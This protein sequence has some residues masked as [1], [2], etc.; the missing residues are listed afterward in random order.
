MIQKWALLAPTDWPALAA[1]NPAKQCLDSFSFV[2][3]KNQ[4]GVAK[5]TEASCP[6]DL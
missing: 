3:A 4:Q 1:C 6:L 2:F 5:D